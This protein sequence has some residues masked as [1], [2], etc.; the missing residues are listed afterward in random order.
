MGER[1]SERAHQREKCSETKA[2]VEKDVQS[3][4]DEAALALFATSDCIYAW[5]CLCVGYRA[6]TRHEHGEYT[7]P[8][9]GEHT[10]FFLKHS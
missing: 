6:E 3:T 7:R 9:K 5:I 1:A 4:P 10:Q 8:G 2:F